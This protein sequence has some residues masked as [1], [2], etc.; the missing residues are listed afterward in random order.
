MLSAVRVAAIMRFW[1][2]KCECR[3]WACCVKRLR[4]GVAL[5]G[6]VGG[7][8]GG[9]RRLATRVVLFRQ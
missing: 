6:C 5:G 1:I 7:G 4:Q 8:V 9:R 3:W 2:A